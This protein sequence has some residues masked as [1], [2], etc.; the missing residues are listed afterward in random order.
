MGRKKQNIFQAKQ[1]ELPCSQDPLS[2]NFYQ[3]EK[4]LKEGRTPDGV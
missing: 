2:E 1:Y 3:I 4:V